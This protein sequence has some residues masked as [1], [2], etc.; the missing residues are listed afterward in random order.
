MVTEKKHAQEIISGSE[1]KDIAKL[2][3]KEVT[4]QYF[5]FIL[6]I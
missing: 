3:S 4:H 6:H 1:S 2:Q 5:Y